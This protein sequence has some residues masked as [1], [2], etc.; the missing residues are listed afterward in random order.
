VSNNS[1]IFRTVKNKDNPYVMIN[2][3]FL[4][5]ERLS[6]KAKGIL[7]YLLSMPDDWKI[8]EAELVK[9]NKD[10]LTSLK[11][12]I[13]ELI[14]LGYIVRTKVRDKEG[15]FKGY[16]Y[17]VYEVPAEIGKSD[18]GKPNNGEPVNGQP[19]TTNNNITNN[20]LTNKDIYT[21]GNV[22]NFQQN[23]KEDNSNPDDG[24]ISDIDK[25]ALEVYK[26][27]PR[28]DGNIE[29]FILAYKKLR[30][31]YTREY[32]ELIIDRYKKL[33]EIKCEDIYHRPDNFFRSGEY[34]NYLDENWDSTLNGAKKVLKSSSNK[35]SSKTL[36]EPSNLEDWVKDVDSLFN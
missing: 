29:T 28:Q 23:S 18:L 21:E 25:E 3:Q 27:M 2:K 6:F 8:Y 1:T 31:K 4:N 10:G 9:H 17:C 33:K 12:G 20:N 5:D 14:E 32:L 22:K 35:K 36:N 24:K 11:S 16:E 26:L 7:A 13:K 34:K 19:H 15:K 30:S